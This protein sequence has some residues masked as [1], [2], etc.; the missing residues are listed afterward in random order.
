MDTFEL[1][2]IAGAVLGSA[3][4]LM[5]INEV[6][7]ILVHPHH[8]EGNVIGIEAAEEGAGAATAKAG[9]A[10][11]AAPIETLLAKADPAEGAKIAKK[12]MTCHTFDQGG[13]NKIGPHLY[14]VIGRDIASVEGFGY[15]GALTELPGAWDFDK[16]NHF[17][18]DPKAFAPGTK[19]SFAGLKKAED[20]ADVL[21]FIAKNQ[22]AELPKPQ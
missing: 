13:A 1:N 22:G 5:V 14:G 15:S 19:M 7:N 21:A 2:K 11:P 6:G 8:L 16:I 3:L 4:F 20:R 17:I 9:P 10:E 18:T 12:C